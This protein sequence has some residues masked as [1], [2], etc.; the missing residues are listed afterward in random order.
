[1]LSCRNAGP[2][3]LRAPN[4]PGR[5]PRT[6]TRARRRA[7]SERSNSNGLSARHTTAGPGREIG[8][9]QVARF[10]SGGEFAGEFI[11][12]VG[13]MDGWMDGWP[14]SRRRGQTQLQG[15]QLQGTRGDGEEQAK[16]TTTPTCILLLICLPGP[17]VV[18]ITTMLAWS[19]YMTHGS[20]YT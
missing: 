19:W 18:S 17:S 10:S 2:S 11:A 1:M 7:F 13:K 6:M 20:I 14:A 16:T 5:P 15:L 12:A 8:S 4:Q 9:L 3:W